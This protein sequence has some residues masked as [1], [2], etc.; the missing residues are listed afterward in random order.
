MWK[1]GRGVRQFFAWCGRSR[2]GVEI[3]LGVVFEQAKMAVDEGISKVQHSKSSNHLIS[4]LYYNDSSLYGI[5]IGS[6]GYAASVRTEKVVFIDSHLI[7]INWLV[8]DEI[9]VVFLIVDCDF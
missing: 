9:N 3:C 5:F 7:R 4:F 8:L 2:R 6:F 1:F